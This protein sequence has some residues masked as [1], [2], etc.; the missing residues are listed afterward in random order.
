MSADFHTVPDHTAITMLTNWRD[1][2][3]RALETIER[4]PHA[5]SYQLKRFVV[6]VAAHLAPGH[7]S[8]LILRVKEIFNLDEMRIFCVVIKRVEIWA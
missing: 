4:V 2:L 8:I 7:V 3:D 6:V 1:R 5:C